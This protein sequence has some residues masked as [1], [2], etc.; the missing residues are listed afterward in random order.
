M[1]LKVYKIDKEYIVL[2]E[3]EEIPAVGQEAYHCSPSAALIAF[4]DATVDRLKDFEFEPNDHASK[5]LIE[6]FG[7]TAV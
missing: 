2:R 6:K 1:V 7:F 3:D 5:E 4:R